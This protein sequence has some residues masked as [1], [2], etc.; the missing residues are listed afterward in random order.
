[1]MTAARGEAMVVPRLSAAGELHS[2][3]VDR[4][5][6]EAVAS[7]WAGGQTVVVDLT[8]VTRWSFLAQAM[9]LGLARELARRRS[10]LVFVGASLSLRLQSQRMDVFTK[11]RE[12]AR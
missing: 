10:S 9:L 7:A 1:M 5:Y 2:V 11:V 3:D 4:F 8:G 6:D 12:L